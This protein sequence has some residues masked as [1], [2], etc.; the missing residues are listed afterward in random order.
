MSCIIHRNGNKEI[1]YLENVKIQRNVHILSSYSLDLDLASYSNLK[2]HKAY[3]DMVE[4]YSERYRFAAYSEDRREE[5]SSSDSD[6]SFSDSEH[7][8]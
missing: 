8:K 7:D 6:Y 3:R 5:Y 1:F 2:M 4:D